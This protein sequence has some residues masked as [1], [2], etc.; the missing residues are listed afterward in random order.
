MNTVF[1]AA[2]YPHKNK[3]FYG[4]FIKEHAR[5][6]SIFSHVFVIY[7]KFTKKGLIPKIKVSEEITNNIT[8]YQLDVSSPIRKFGIHDLLTKKAYS[9]VL[10]KIQSKHQIN[11]IH[12][13]VRD[14]FTKLVTKIKLVQKLPIIV[15]EHSSFYKYGIKNLSYNEQAKEKKEIRN[16]FLN[17]KIKYV[18]PVSQ[19]LGSVLINEFNVEKHKIKIIPNVASNMFYYK[20]KK[21]KDIHK[22]LLV[23]QWNAPKNPMLFL[24]VL[25]KLRRKLKERISINWVGE[26]LQIEDVKKFT[27]DHLN[28]FNIKFWGL[29]KK[30]TIG[31]LLRDSDFL[32]HPSDSENLPSIIIES[33][34]SGTPVLTH[35]VG[36]IPE[37]IDNSNGI[38]CEPKSIE[39]FSQKF[40]IMLSKCRSYDHKLI[41]KKAQEL[42]SLEAVSKSLKLIYDE[43]LN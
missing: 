18:L 4:A 11:L 40:E 13:H 38:M 15:T 27:K 41:A 8:I 32:V 10:S 34:C 12:I 5:A 20:E 6:V 16:W 30:E 2:W 42:Y 9:D 3:V 28:D 17:P 23:A 31:N 43:I 36:G 35:R 19:Q 24:K 37:L 22:V 33:L 7:L 39:D 26:G 25:Q 14:K 1:I 21:N 29:Q